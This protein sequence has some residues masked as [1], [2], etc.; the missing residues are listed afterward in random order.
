M[1]L[2]DKNIVITPSIGQTADPKIVFSGA[3]STVGPQNIALQVYPTSNGTLSFEGSAG[4]LFGISNSL[5]GTIFSANDISGIPSI[6]VLDTGLVKLA[7]YNGSVTVNTATSISNAK[8]TV[9]GGS[10]INGTLT[11]TTIVSIIAQDYVVSVTANSATT[12]LDL[13]Q[14]NTFY[15]TMSASTTF[16]FSNVPT[17][18]NLTNFSIITYNSAGGYAISWP[19]GVTWSGGQT[20]AR[21]TTSGKSDIYTF[22]TLN[23]G[24]SIIGS[25]SILNY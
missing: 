25:L 20:P 18:S 15:V 4:Q 14:G 23:A 5:S 9:Q 22:F 3:S 1:A 13:S 21:T 7:Q 6:E 24:S 16:A 11:A 8:L 19:A 12:T 10:Y 17:G 2:S